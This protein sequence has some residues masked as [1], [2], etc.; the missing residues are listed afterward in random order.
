MS[1]SHLLLGPDSVEAALEAG[2]ATLIA[3][4]LREASAD[5]DGH[6]TRRLS[7]DITSVRGWI[8]DL[9]AS[10][11]EGDSPLA[12]GFVFR[13]DGTTAPRALGG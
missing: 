1:D 9:R 12:Y 7:H 10:A 4:Q 13:R 2:C 8:A 5:D 3:L 11:S 6:A